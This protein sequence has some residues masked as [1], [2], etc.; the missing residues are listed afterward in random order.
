MAKHKM[1]LQA[2]T[3]VI[4]INKNMLEVTGDTIPVRAGLYQK[5]KKEEVICQIPSSLV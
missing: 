5:K 2:Q 3:G 4:L 1:M